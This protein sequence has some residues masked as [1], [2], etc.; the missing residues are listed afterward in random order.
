MVAEGSVSG[1]D[2]GP[3]FGMTEKRERERDKERETEGARDGRVG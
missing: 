3:R 1:V 2:S